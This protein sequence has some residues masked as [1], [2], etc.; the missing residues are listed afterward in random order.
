VLVVGGNAMLADQILGELAPLADAG[1][2]VFVFDYRGYGAS[3]GRPRLLAIIGDKLE[4]ARRL[5]AEGQG[6]LAFYGISM[7]GIVLA[8]VLPHLPPDVFPERFVIDGSPARSRPS[9]AHPSST[10]SRACR[11]TREPSSSSARRR[12]GRAAPAVP[13]ADPGDRDRRRPRGGSTP[14]S[15]IPSWTAIPASTKPG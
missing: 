5:A 15:P 14:T 8:N 1:L 3:E 9:A 4:L 7:G 2:E 6:P 11:A 13:G 12:H 10:P